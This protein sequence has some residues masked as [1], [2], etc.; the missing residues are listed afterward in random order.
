M[1]FLCLSLATHFPTRSNQCYRFLVYLSR[2]CIFQQIQNILCKLWTTVWAIFLLSALWRS[3]SCDQLSPTVWMSHINLSPTD[4]IRFFTN[5][6][7]DSVIAKGLNMHYFACKQVLL[8]EEVPEVELL[9]QRECALVVLMAVIALLYFLGVLPIYAPTNN[10]CDCL[11]LFI[12]L[13]TAFWRRQWHPTPVLLP[14]KSHG[15]RSLV[16]CSPWGR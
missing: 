14:G 12:P 11:F 1:S 4:R 13:P 16:G 15:R 2:Q 3:L 7:Y 9:D 6:C 8:Q 10:A 5:F